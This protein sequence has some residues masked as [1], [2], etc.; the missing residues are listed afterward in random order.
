MTAFEKAILK[1]FRYQPE[2]GDVIRIWRNNRWGPFPV[3]ERVGTKSFGYLRAMFKGRSL[4]VHRMAWLLQTG[5]LPSRRFDVDH[6][7][8]K[9][10]DNRWINLRLASRGENNMNSGNPTNNTTGQKGVHPTRGRWFSR[11]KVDGRVIH[12]GVFETFCEAVA[13]RK[14]G[15][16][17]FFGEFTKGKDYVSQV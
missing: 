2:T 4:A 1:N 3:N 6:V 15:E 13:A 11:I 14:A 8:G 12:L 10:S 5:S 9:R 7:N 16:V 17:K